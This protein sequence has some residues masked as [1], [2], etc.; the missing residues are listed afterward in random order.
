MLDAA[1]GTSLVPAAELAG[2]ITGLLGL[3][4]A[5]R[6]ALVRRRRARGD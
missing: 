4:L 2:W 6:W 3:A 1:F 5:V